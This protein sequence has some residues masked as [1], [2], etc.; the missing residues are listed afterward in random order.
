[1]QDL[2]GLADLFLDKVWLTI[3]FPC[4]IFLGVYFTVKS[5]FFQFTAFTRIVKI[6]FS[7]LKH[8]VEK[9]PSGYHP[10]KMFFAAI[11]GCIGIGNVVGVCTAVKVGGPG[12]IFWIWVTAIIGSLV[13]Y[14]E[15]F[16]GMRYREKVGS[17]YSGGPFF[18]LKHAF[19]S[20][21]FAYFAAVLL[22]VYG[23]EVY[24]FSTLVNTFVINWHLPQTP[25]VV[26]F[27][28][29]V[30]VGVYGGLN[31]IGKISATIVPVF[32]FIFLCMCF[33]VIGSH[34][35]QLPTIF[36]DI[37]HS[38]FSGHAAI[39]GFAGSSAIVAMTQGISWGCYSG[40]IGIGYAS[41]IH[42]ESSET[43]PQ[44]QASL[45]ILG[46]FIDTFIICTLSLT[47]IMLTGVWHS[48]LPVVLY[49]QNSLA[50]I[51]PYMDVFMPVL[52]GLLGYSTIIAY[53]GVG[54]KNAELIAGGI[55]KKAYM[56]YGIT[57]LAIFSYYSTDY[58]ALLMRIA[59]VFLLTLNIAG[60]FIL[61][62]EVKFGL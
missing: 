55:G 19:T 30:L 48:D 61:R 57:S 8:D 53:F 59:G 54:L 39:G 51:I 10:L 35:S 33:W 23:V 44:K 25:T 40:D 58:A 21:F 20:K 9:S 60:F 41:V 49:M 22:C 34:L 13:K 11:G 31:R 5:K 27:L 37:F 28:V 47:V 62:K 29:L 38:A 6:F 16:L 14:S 7:Y 52:F 15:I 56:V 17:G 46:V 4:L 1:M 36:A 2:A 3:G 32:I 12:A 24:I 50:E 26:G 45:A 42:S 43:V 18:Y